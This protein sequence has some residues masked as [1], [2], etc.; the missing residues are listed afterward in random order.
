MNRGHDLIA[1]LSRETHTSEFIIRANNG[2][3]LTEGVSEH[4]AHTQGI[5][6]PLTDETYEE[7]KQQRPGTS[8][9]L[10]IQFNKQVHT[11]TP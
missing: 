3:E 11:C 1:L 9:S 8:N 4:A 10:I 2:L 6:A 7:T 5:D